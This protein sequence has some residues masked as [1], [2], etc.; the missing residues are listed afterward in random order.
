M[1]LFFF[2]FKK[3]QKTWYS[4]FLQTSKAQNHEFNFLILKKLKNIYLIVYKLQK[5]KKYAFNFL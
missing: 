4:I 5:L 1:D 2:N 3:A